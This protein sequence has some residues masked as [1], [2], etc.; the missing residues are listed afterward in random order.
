MP[1]GVQIYLVSSFS[2]SFGQGY[3]LRNDTFRKLVGLPSLDAKPLEPEIAKSY[4]NKMK[5]KAAAE[6]KYGPAGSG[7]FAREDIGANNSNP[8]DTTGI[9]V[10]SPGIAVSSGASL[11][12]K[13]E[14]SIAG[15][16]MEHGNPGAPEKRE[17]MIYIPDEVMEAA[18]KGEAI[19]YT[20]PRP[21]EIVPKDEGV[22]VS[23]VDAKMIVGRRGKK[24]GTA[25]KSGKSKGRR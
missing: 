10:L 16:N 18:N 15:A 12:T 3:A 25:S 21:I 17:S 9:G 1:A 13:R 14:S 23:P 22:T 19:N 11:A 8:E 7:V 2:Y 24:K 5:A 6:A 4:I 20:A